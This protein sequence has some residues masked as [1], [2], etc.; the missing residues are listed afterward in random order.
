MR[1]DVVICIFV[2]IYF[3]KKIKIDEVVSWL[4]PLIKVEG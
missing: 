1:V 2:E 4:F 3:L